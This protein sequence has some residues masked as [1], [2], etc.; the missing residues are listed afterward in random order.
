MPQSSSRVAIGGGDRSSLTLL[1][2][3]D[4]I[5]RDEQD[6][7]GLARHWLWRIEN[8]KTCVRD[9]DALP[10]HRVVDM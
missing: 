4:R 1:A 8:L 6:L 3:W 9:H 2:Y 5:L 7:R 10:Q